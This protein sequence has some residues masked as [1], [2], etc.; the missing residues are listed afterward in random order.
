MRSVH[1]LVLCAVFA[2][3]FPS[4]AHA[5]AKET[6]LYSFGTNGGSADGDAPLGQLVF[7]AAGNM[8]GTTQV[9]GIAD[10]GLCQEG[11]GTVFE[12][13]PA[14][15]GNWTETIIHQFMAGIDGA[16]PRSALIFDSQGNLY[17][18]T[19]GSGACI[20]PNCGTVFEL[21]PSPGGQWNETLLYSF[22]GFPDGEAPLASVVFDSHG[23]LY[24]TTNAGG[25]YQYGTVFELS[26]PSVPG[27]PWTETILYSFCALGN[28][29]SC[30]DGAGPESSVVFDKQ[31]NLYGTTING[32]GLWGLVYEL[33]KGQDGTWTE[34]VLYKFSKNGGNPEAGLV[35]NA[36]VLY[37]TMYSGGNESPTCA[38]ED[39]WPYPRT[40]G[41][42]FEL[43][44]LKHGWLGQTL[45]LSGS[46]GGNPTAPLTL[47]G[48]AGYTT[49]FLGGAG[50]GVVLEVQSA[51]TALY[52]F[53][54]NGGGC[55][56]GAYPFGGVI[57]RAGKV[58]GTASWGGDFKQGV[59]FSI[60]P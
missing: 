58:Y 39:I 18:T 53:C 27:G 43:T 54:P 38:Q 21:S 42:M 12:L 5:Q 30:P 35:M 59:V 3:A 2:A 60:T 14:G 41:G 7:D 57:V 24:G 26:P 10:A 32:P 11:C 20:P 16:G 45:L 6:V 33:S 19:S 4:F 34:S 13:T 1:A 17:G 31:G 15:D 50:Y 55:P 9:G 56:D 40:C 48:N 52:T 8:Y 23:N 47:S 25:A 36:G 51:A 29:E 37:G 28:S 49:S 46:N 44:P 22:T